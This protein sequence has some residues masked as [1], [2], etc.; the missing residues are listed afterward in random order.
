MKTYI[1]TIEYNEE[2]EEIEC[3]SEEI[4]QE[5]TSFF[6]GEIEVSEWWDEETLEL[7]K[8]GYIFGET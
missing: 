2:T 8:D 7:M 6:Y 5:H 4:I 3:L 1:L